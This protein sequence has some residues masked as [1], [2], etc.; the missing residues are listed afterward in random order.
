MPAHE[1]R[2]LREREQL[3]ERQAADGSEHGRGTTRAG[4]GVDGRIAVECRA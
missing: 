2:D 3:E 4:A 1:Q